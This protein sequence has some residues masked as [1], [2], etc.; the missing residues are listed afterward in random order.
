MVNSSDAPITRSIED[1]RAALHAAD[2]L[3][4]HARFARMIVRHEAM[5]VCEWNGMELRRIAEIFDCSIRAVRKELRCEYRW[6]VPTGWRDYVAELT[7][8]AWDTASRPFL[9]FPPLG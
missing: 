1:A 2:D 4:K 8:I 6:T 9:K 7:N 5:Q 3:V